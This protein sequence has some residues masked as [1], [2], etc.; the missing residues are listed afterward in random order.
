MKLRE[1]VVV[2]TVRTAIGKS[3][4]KG[5]EKKGMFSETS[6]QDML[7]VV[8]KGIVE[9]VQ[10]RAPRFNPQEIE[11][12]IVGCLSQ[13]GE[14][15]GNIG[16]VA[17][18]IAGLPI[19]SAGMSLNRYCPSGLQAINF[20]AMSIMCGYGDIV[21]AGG[22]ENMSH[23][24]MG[25]DMQI[26]LQSGHTVFFSPKIQ[27]TGVFIPMGVAAEMVAERYN[28]EK[29]D[30]DRFGLWSHQKAVRAQREGLFD[31]HIIP[32]EVTV[33][34]EKKVAR[35]DETPRA[36]CL[37]NPEEA[38]KK[39]SQLPP[40]FKENGK[41]TAG[42][43]S[44]ICDAA[45]VVM[46]M[47][48]DK[49]EELGLEP[50]VRLKAMAVAGSE[51]SIMLL[52]PILAT[53]KALARTG[54]KMDDIEILEPNEAFASPVLAFCKEFGIDFQD[55]RINPTGGAIALGHPIGATGVLYFG[56]MVH[57][58]K[59]KNLKYG[60]QT[61]CGGGGVAVTTIVERI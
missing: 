27:E 30:M 44:Q 7:A 60:L 54:L 50:L 61:L 12:V 23:Y 28:L 41:V 14:Q 43:S 56:E 26:P 38:M 6:S 32:M 42:N 3:G 13:V 10:K 15:G 9:R 29:E 21:I 11:D 36:L 35:V 45:G 4:W 59:R 53:R 55:P 31:D 1:V 51:P 58:M 40:R 20:A 47:S 18:L 33:G 37:D 22:V 57:E 17:M 19:E 52:G 2:D 5:M 39:I 48:A 46:L 16:R 34:G 49:A 8:L 25:S 24:P